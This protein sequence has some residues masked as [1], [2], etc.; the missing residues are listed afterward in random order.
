MLPLESTDSKDHSRTDLIH[1]S[2]LFGHMGLCRGKSTKASRI[3]VKVERS[4]SACRRNGLVPTINSRDVS[5]T[6]S[7]V[8]PT[9]PSTKNYQRRFHKHHS[10]SVNP[11]FNLRITFNCLRALRNTSS[12][13]IGHEILRLMQGNPKLPFI[14][15]IF[16]SCS[17]R[18]FGID[19]ISC[20]LP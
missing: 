13:F 14:A 9:C 6:I 4:D 15:S 18:F 5:S 11:V 7:F 16:F 17:I 8:S 1:L 19:L 3:H 12:K 2:K 10:A 20:L